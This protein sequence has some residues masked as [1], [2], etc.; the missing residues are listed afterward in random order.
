MKMLDNSDEGQM[1]GY[2]NTPPV[3]DLPQD[4]AIRRWWEIEGEDE[5]EGM[6]VGIQFFAGKDVAGAIMVCDNSPM[7]QHSIA[8]EMDKLGV[9]PVYLQYTEWAGFAQTFTEDCD[10]C[11]SFTE[12]SGC[13]G[14][15]CVEGRN[16]DYIGIESVS[17]EDEE[18]GLRCLYCSD[19]FEFRLY[20]QTPKPAA[21]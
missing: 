19:E 4:D 9:P 15:V 14:G 20:F 1:L 3:S 8:V 17:I 11:A 7:A 16:T 2:E 18:M 12:N 13:I 6:V 5:Y 21:D 10:W